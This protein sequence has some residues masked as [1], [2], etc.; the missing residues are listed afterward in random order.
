M[1]KP[2]KK[3]VKYTYKTLEKLRKDGWE[4]DVVE[5]WIGNPAIPLSRVRRDLWGL[6]DVLAINAKEFGQTDIESADSWPIL[7]IQSTSIGALQPHIEKAMKEPRLR[8]VLAS[9]IVFQIWAWGLRKV[10]VKAVR[11]KVKKIN[12]TQAGDDY[13]IEEII[14]S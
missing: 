1:K 4:P 5:R 12:F 8:L 9:G 14:E 2:R 6:I 7:G 11:W 10:G 3:P 13:I